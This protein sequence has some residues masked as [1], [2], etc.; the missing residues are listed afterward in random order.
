[1]TKRTACES[2]NPQSLTDPGQL[3]ANLPAIL[4]FFPRE[5]IVLATFESVQGSS[6]ALGPILRLDI[7]STEGLRELFD[8]GGVIADCDLVFA[9]VISAEVV[10]PSRLSSGL[11]ESLG[12]IEDTV[13][14]STATLAGIWGCEEIV[15]GSRYTSLRPVAGACGGPGW[16]AG[17][18]SSVVGAAAMEQWVAA[19]KLPEV[20]REDVF[21]RFTRGNPHLGAS[22]L[23]RI[24]EAGRHGLGRWS[25][26]VELVEE[27]GAMIRE[28][29]GLSV[30]E[31]LADPD[32]LELGAVVLSGVQ[33]RDAV[34]GDVLGMPSAA[35]PV[36]LAAAKTLRG[37]ARANALCLYALAVIAEGFPME[38]NPALITALAEVPQHSLSRLIIHL[39]H[40]GETDS[41]LRS[42][43]LGS[44]V[45]R[46][47]LSGS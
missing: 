22:E 44:E 18:V 26:G 45:A 3:I 35:G 21:H 6:F 20:S 8:H 24:E 27:L 37:P 34:V 9:F 23:G 36:M 47:G 33:L 1:M 11:L 40:T 12:I 17:T 7:G 5:S 29:E 15:T 32:L 2:P 38:A 19:G 16:V 46:R 25:S 39:L 43:S 4:G 13:A 10:H 30:D 14:E 31:L 41:L 42:V 28:G